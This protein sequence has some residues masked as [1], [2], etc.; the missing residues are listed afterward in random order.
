MHFVILFLKWEKARRVHTDAELL[1]HRISL[2]E[3]RV[4]VICL[5][6][7]CWI[8]LFIPHISLQRNGVAHSCLSFPIFGKWN[9]SWGWEREIRDWIANDE[10]MT[11]SRYSLAFCLCILENCLLSFHFS[12]SH[13][14]S[15]WWKRRR[16]AFSSRTEIWKRKPDWQRERERH[17]RTP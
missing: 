4:R 10:V 6:F 8:M 16:S 3:T 2:Q 14:R 9:Y 11:R 7:R 5:C 17:I 12:P 1:H 15:K 13:L